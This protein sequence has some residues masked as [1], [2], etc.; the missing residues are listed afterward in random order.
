MQEKVY[1]ATHSSTIEIAG[2]KLRCYVTED[3]KRI[4]DCDD[5]HNFFAA[6]ENGADISPEDALNLAELVKGS[7]VMSETTNPREGV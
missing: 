3:G 1:K 2:V 4:I 5:V 6:L 7:K